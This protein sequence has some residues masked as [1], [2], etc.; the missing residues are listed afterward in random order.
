MVWGGV[1]RGDRQM[2]DGHMT[3]EEPQSDMLNK[4]RSHIIAAFTDFNSSISS[5]FYFYCF[6]LPM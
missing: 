1:D 6:F 5:C 2:L 4:G 3:N